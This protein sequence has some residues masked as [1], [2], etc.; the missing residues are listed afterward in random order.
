M[1]CF[2]KEMRTHNTPSQIKVPMWPIRWL[3][4]IL[5]GSVHHKAGGWVGGVELTRG[6][7]RVY[8]ARTSRLRVGVE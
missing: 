4:E 1:L 3:R 6:R 2:L 8:C 7:K 5:G